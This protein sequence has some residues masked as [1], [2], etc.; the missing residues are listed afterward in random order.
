M[1]LRNER[2]KVAIIAP[3]K[4][5]I[6][7]TKGG[8]IE[9]LATHWINKNE[10]YGD[11]EI[12]VFSPFDEKAENISSAYKHTQ[13][14]YY[15]NNS[16]LKIFNKIWGGLYHFSKRRIIAKRG[17]ILQISS[18]LRAV[19]PDIIIA[20]GSFLQVP[21]LAKFGKPVILHVHTDILNKLEPKCHQIVSLCRKVWTNSDYIT[22][23]VIDGSGIPE[24]IKTLPNAIDTKK[25]LSGN[26][27]E[28]RKKYNISDDSKV[29]IYCGRVDPIKGVKELV[30]AFEKA[31]IDNLILLIVGGSRFADSGI[32]TYE[33][34][35]HEYVSTH[36]LKV[37]FTGF[38]YP[39]ELPSYYKA[40]NFSVCPSICNEAAGLVI[41]EARSAGLPV[42]ATKNGGIPEYASPEGS[43][44]IDYRHEF[45]IDDLANAICT[46]NKET[47][48]SNRLQIQ[49]SKG[50]EKFDIDTYYHNFVK[51]LEEVL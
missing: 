18:D 35:I 36:D 12:I 31:N 15:S 39:E 30:L 34:E 5:P 28:I 27:N 2:I 51:Y 1:A 17:F 32:S 38:V 40:A 19:N 7:N 14:K 11:V 44:L 21:Q 50:V 13:V 47:S 41:V 22:S 46:M 37:I 16:S 33:K 26:G 20:E 45:F 6:P 48:E 8:A 29:M 42:I 25:F 4:L 9:T 43:I 24:K 10:E 23:Q 3:D 49:S